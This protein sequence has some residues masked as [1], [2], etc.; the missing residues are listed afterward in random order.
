MTIGDYFKESPGVPPEEIPEEIREQKAA[1]SEH[2][3]KAAKAI[4]AAA[5]R[6]FGPWGTVAALLAGLGVFLTGFADLVR[7]MGW[8]Q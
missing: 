8:F 4:A 2:N 7:E 6:A 3:E 1:H 5:K